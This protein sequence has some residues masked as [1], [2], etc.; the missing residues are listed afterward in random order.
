MEGMGE[1]ADEPLCQLCF[2]HTRDDR[3]TQ[4]G[5]LTDVR[6]RWAEVRDYYVGRCVLLLRTP[7]PEH[8]VS[9]RPALALPPPSPCPVPG[10]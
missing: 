2:K 3:L 1:G 7:H 8:D 4:R 9:A 6:A 10:T 5:N